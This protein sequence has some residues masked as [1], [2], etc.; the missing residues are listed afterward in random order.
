[1]HRD[2]L[3][4]DQIRKLADNVASQLQLVPS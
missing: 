4:S 3:I 2:S 1:M